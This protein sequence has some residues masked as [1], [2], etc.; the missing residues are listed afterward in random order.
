MSY[1]F[2]EGFLLHSNGQL[3]AADYKYIDP[4][5]ELSIEIGQP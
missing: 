2:L 5:I 4:S 1:N 3:G